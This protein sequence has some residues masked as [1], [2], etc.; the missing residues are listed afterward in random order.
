ML[1]ACGAQL[2]GRQNVLGRAQ[3]AACS[4]QRPDIHVLLHGNVSSGLGPNVA[5]NKHGELSLLEPQLFACSRQETAVNAHATSNLP[6]FA[7][8]LPVLVAI[9]FA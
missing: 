4:L 5:W 9:R 1:C 6:C 3:A 2:Q 8:S 7:Q